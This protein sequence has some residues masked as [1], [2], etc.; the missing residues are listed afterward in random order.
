MKSMYRVI[1]IF[2]IA[3][4]IVLGVWYFMSNKYSNVVEQSF[5][6]ASVIKP[7]RPITQFEL[8]DDSGKTFNKQSLHGH[9]TLL[10][11]GYPGCPDICP[12]TL[13]IVRDAWNTYAPGKPAAHFVFAS[14]TPEP[15]ESGNLKNFVQQFRPDFIGVSGTPDA[16]QQFSDQLGIYVQEQQDRI[17]HTTSLMLI[18]PKGRLAAVFSPPLN[19][20]QLV[21]ELNILTNRKS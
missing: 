7:A 11:F 16:M 3:L 15:A 10:F 18:D 21:S 5:E 1:I 6:V 13:G 8:F 12:Q 14:I 2:L 20:Q 9:W 4:T 19:A 17:A